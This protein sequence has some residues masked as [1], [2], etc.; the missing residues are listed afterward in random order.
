[1]ASK[2]IKLRP[3]L[4]PNFVVG[5]TGSD[6]PP[7]FSIGELSS[8]ELEKLLEEFCSSMRSKRQDGESNCEN[9]KA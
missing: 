9:G 8:D 4:V 5:D 6:Q 3:L 7:K 1:M 2:T